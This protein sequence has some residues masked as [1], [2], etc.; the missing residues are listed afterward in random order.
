MA[1]YKW[2][3]SLVFYSLST[4]ASTSL[5]KGSSQLSVSSSPS[6]AGLSQQPN[7]VLHW[8]P[9]A[10]ASNNRHIL[11]S[12]LHFLW[13]HKLWRVWTD[14]GRGVGPRGLLKAATVALELVTGERFIQG[15]KVIKEIQ[16]VH[17]NQIITNLP[18]NGTVP[19]CM[20]VVPWTIPRPCMTK[21]RISCQPNTG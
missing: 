4:S 7:F 10:Q 15:G 6:S 5:A 11:Q 21:V 17:T 19:A 16:Y 12:H 9:P 3:G 1:S 8:L 2:D 20:F 18:A 14:H 13:C